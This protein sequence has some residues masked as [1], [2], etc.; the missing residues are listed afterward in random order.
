MYYDGRVS[1][2]R[3]CWM[4]H[5]DHFMRQDLLPCSL[6]VTTR[7]AAWRDPL[8]HE[9]LWLISLYVKRRTSQHAGVGDFKAF[10]ISAEHGFMQYNLGSDITA[11]CVNT[12]IAHLQMLRPA[13]CIQILLSETTA[14]V[15]YDKVLYD[16]HHQ[17]CQTLVVLYEVVP[18]EY[19]RLVWFCRHECCV[20]GLL[21]VRQTSRAR[22][23]KRI[24]YEFSYPSPLN[25]PQGSP[26][27]KSYLVL[28]PVTSGGT[29]RWGSY[30][31]GA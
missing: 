3:N 7:W 31:A 12:F 27:D 17:H 10:R 24:Y 15:A 1:W 9:V 29:L 13:L 6:V 16:I 4:L 26:F 28:I 11:Q 2:N 5:S 30:S 19:L 22:M 8:K 23:Q 18:I 20:T 14:A 21:G 25:S